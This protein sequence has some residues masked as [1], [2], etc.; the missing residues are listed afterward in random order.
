MTRLSLLAGFAWLLAAGAAHANPDI[1]V[2]SAITYHVEDESVVG[3]TLE[4]RFDQYFSNRTIRDFDR[5]GDGA[6]DESESATLRQKAFDPLSQDRFH[7]HV[8]ANGEPKAFDVVDFAPRVEAE[9]VLVYRFTARFDRP[10][11][12]R[13]VPLIVSQHDD[14][15][16]F[17]FSFSDGEFLLVQG[18]F[19]AACKFRIGRGSGRL[20]GHKQTVALVCGA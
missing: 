13:D 19:D 10:V 17:D 1:W 18:P 9:E 7:L 20:S 3:L 11:P 15:V 16:I 5:S 4:W 2:K 6:F 12:Y 8:L 14:A